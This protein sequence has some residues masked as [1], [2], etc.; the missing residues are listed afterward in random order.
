MCQDPQLAGW[1]ALSPKHCFALACTGSKEDLGTD[2]DG[3]VRSTILSLRTGV[4]S[5]V[6]MINY[7]FGLNHKDCSSH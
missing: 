2:E 4:P 1:G 6:R 5:A 7:G 3:A